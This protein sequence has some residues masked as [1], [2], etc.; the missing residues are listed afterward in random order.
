[1]AAGEQNHR[2]PGQ[3]GVRLHLAS[4]VAAVEH[5]HAHVEQEQVER[6][7]GPLGQQQPFDR[8]LRLL[9][10][11]RPQPPGG[12][13]GLE[14]LAV[15]RVVVD[16]EHAGLLQRPQ[17]PPLLLDHAGGPVGRQRQLEE[18]RRADARLAL[19]LQLA[20]EQADELAA[21]R[22]PQPGPAVL[23]RSRGVGLGERLEHA[24]ALLRR[25]AD[26]GVLHGEPQ[27]RRSIRGRP[28]RRI[29]LG[30]GPADADVHL[31]G[32]GEL[33]C[34]AHQVG[35]HLPQPLRV[36]EHAGRQVRLDLAVQFDLLAVGADGELLAGRLDEVAKVEPGA[37]DL[38]LAGLDLGEVEDV[39]D[40]RQ[41]RVGAGAGDRGVVQALLGQ[42]LRREQVEH[43]DHAVE[44]RTDL[45]AHVGEELAFGAALRLGQLDL[46]KHRLL[47]LGDVVHGAEPAD[48]RAGCVADRNERFEHP[49]VAAV[50]GADAAFEVADRLPATVRLGPAAGVLDRPLVGHGKRIATQVGLQPRRHLDRLV[51][52]QRLGRPVAHRLQQRRVDGGEP[53]V[54]VE[55]VDADAGVLQDRLQPQPLGREP[56]VGLFAG[57]GLGPDAGD[58][59][60]VLRGDLPGLGVR[61]DRDRLRQIA[62]PLVPVH[63]H[64]QVDDLVGRPVLGHVQPARLG[65]FAHPQ[66]HDALQQRQPAVHEPERHA[67]RDD[68]TE[69]LHADRGGTAGFAER[70]GHRE[71]P[72]GD[73]APQPGRPVHGERIHD[74]VDTQ[75]PQSRS[76]GVGDRRAGRPDE[77]GRDRHQR[78]AGGRDRDQPGDDARKQRDDLDAA[79]PQQ[80]HDRRGDPAGRGPKLRVEQHEREGVGHGEAAAAVEAPPAEPKQE[81]AEDR[82]RQAVAAVAAG[83]GPLPPRADRDRRSER[84]EPADDVHDGRAGEVDEAERGEP[85]RLGPAERPAPGP[86]AD[87]RIDRAADDDAHQQVRLQPHP[88]GD[89][90]ADDRRRRRAEHQL[91]QEE[92]RQRGRAED[93]HRA[94]LPGPAG[95]P[96]DAEHDREPDRREQQHRDGAVEQVLDRHIDRVLRP[97]HACFEQAE[98]G[99]HQKDDRRGGE[100]PNRIETVRRGRD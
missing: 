91:E 57:R 65:R 49:H 93:R 47:P 87:E 31:A 67:G 45:V 59:A 79:A 32:L 28:S 97:H 94:G 41:Q 38:H 29:R 89:R 96:A 83:G 48:Q 37:L 42:P 74:V 4:D 15:G 22:Q 76:R 5:R 39:V 9:A 58:D 24:A 70:A 61:L 56:G 33:D 77:R 11:L 44:R 69:Q 1:M 68:R 14:D 72:V 63:L 3:L 60:V 71:Q 99:L 98:A 40:Q 81:A 73:R 75:P 95:D 26:A 20:A 78:M 17:R 25:H 23:P 88:L 50:E 92:R 19:H 66:R 35:Q 21:D 8:E 51:P 90:P 34:V 43:A 82:E 62:A 27:R 100:R 46:R 64:E 13:L 52:Q 80:A 85:A 16:D 86:V 30:L 53:A 6:L 18:E 55:L 7:S 2:Q 54:G 84:R 36:A 10:H 12:E